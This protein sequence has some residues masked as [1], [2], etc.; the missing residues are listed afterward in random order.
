M[1]YEIN[2]G[3]FFSSFVEAWKRQHSSCKSLSI[4]CRKRTRNNAVFLIT[5]G[6]KVVA[7]FSIPKRILEEPNPLKEFASAKA[8]IRT[9]LSM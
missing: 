9:I 5:N 3:D 2:T 6:Y 1:K 4:E 8:S 7:Q